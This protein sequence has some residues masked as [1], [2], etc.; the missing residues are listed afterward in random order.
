MAHHA[1]REINKFY[2]DLISMN[3]PAGLKTYP[4]LKRRIFYLEQA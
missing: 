4:K 1:E 2:P 3:I